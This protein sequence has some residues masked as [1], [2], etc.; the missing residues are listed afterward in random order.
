RN[1]TIQ[2]YNQYK[3]TTP[4]CKPILE[5]GKNVRPCAAMHKIPH[6]HVQPSSSRSNGIQIRPT[7]RAMVRSGN[8]TTM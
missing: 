3:S 7:A 5:D 4:S 1:K 8:C 6:H 2:D